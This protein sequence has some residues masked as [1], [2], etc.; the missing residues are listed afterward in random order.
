MKSRDTKPE[1]MLQKQF[2][3]HGI[4]VATHVRS[5]PGT[6]DLV[7]ADDRVAIFVNGCYWH[8]HFNCSN[9]S[10]TARMSDFWLDR[11]ARVISQDS[12]NFIRLHILGWTALTAWECEI[13]AY[14]NR[15][16]RRI[17][18]VVEAKRDESC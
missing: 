6:P 1:I 7:L 8:R 14:P 3:R 15:V 17:I 9:A 2:R 13:K 16:Y 11:F 12:H 4:A 18:N 10:L 5:L